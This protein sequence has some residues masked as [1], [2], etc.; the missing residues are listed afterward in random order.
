MSCPLPITLHLITQS[1]PQSPT[2]P[3]SFPPPPPLRGR[4]ADAFGAGPDKPDFLDKVSNLALKF[5][6]LGIAAIVGSY[7][8]AA[9]WMYTGNRQANRLRTRFSAAVLRQDVA[10]FDVQS[11]TGGCSG[12]WSFGLVVSFQKLLGCWVAAGRRLLRVSWDGKGL[13]TGGRVF[14]GR[15]GK[16]MEGEQ[17]GGYAGASSTA[18]RYRRACTAPSTPDRGGHWVAGPEGG[19][20]R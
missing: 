17:K 12:L 19:A 3:H 7:L 10:F 11:T 6:Y 18:C 2:L 13:G 1:Q 14:G 16:V 5:L 8:E 15:V 9:V 4:H 20:V